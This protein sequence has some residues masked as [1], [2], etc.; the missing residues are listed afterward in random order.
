MACGI[1]SL[2]M[3]PTVK[4]LVKSSWE[5]KRRSACCRV[6]AG[7]SHSCVC[8][9]AMTASPASTV[10]NCPNMLALHTNSFSCTPAAATETWMGRHQ[11][12]RSHLQE[13]PEQAQVC[14]F[15][16]CQG[17]FSHTKPCEHITHPHPPSLTP[18][19]V[20]HLLQNPPV[21]LLI[22]PCLCPPVPIRPIPSLYSWYPRISGPHTQACSLPHT[23][24]QNFGDRA[25][26]VAA[27]TLWSSLPAEIHNAAS[28]DTSKI[29]PDNTPAHQGLRCLV[30]STI[31]GNPCY[32]YF[33]NIGFVCF[34]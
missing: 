32:F 33:L 14:A 29:T 13:S 17:F 4:N 8:R 3:I 28:L 22:P 21:H 26:S 10:R 7:R 1:S 2:L 12:D 16:S 34:I 15:L 19:Q 11:G 6:S 30:T 20:P 31:P 24:L 23:S 27:G 5:R 25:F 18:G 9:S